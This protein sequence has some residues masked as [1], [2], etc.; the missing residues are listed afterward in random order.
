MI[1]IRRMLGFPQ[2]MGLLLVLL[3]TSRGQSVGA[4]EPAKLREIELAYIDDQ[5][6]HSATFQSNTQHLICNRN[7]IFTAYIKTRNADYTSQNWRLVRSVDAGRNFTLVAEGMAATNPPVI[8]S[9]DDN[10]LYLCRVDWN[11]NNTSIDCYSAASDYREVQTLELPGVAGGK[12]A[13]AFDP[14]RKRLCFITLDGVLHRIGVNGT[15]FPTV[16]L[17]ESGKKAV[18][19]YPSLHFD[20]RNHLYFC[21]TTVA[22]GKYLY[23]DIHVIRSVDGGDRW[24]TLS[25]E[26]LKFPF[27]ADDGGPSDMISLKDE[28]DVTTWLASALPRFGKLHAIYETQSDP[29][30]Y[31]YVRF[32]TLQGKEEFRISPR[33]G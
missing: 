31:N 10:N 24:E 12:F 18:L 9:D 32:D 33:F 1:P 26:Q 15:A 28:F 6:I 17:L 4:D 25:G 16:K 27:A 21:W 20:E 3:A 22:H 19:Q 11:N 5:V 8:E 13:M 14:L 2:F 23:Y 30:R 29:R 7:G